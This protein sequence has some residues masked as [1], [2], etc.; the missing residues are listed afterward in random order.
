MSLYDDFDAIR[1]KSDQ[2]AGWSSG[3]KLLQSQMQLKKANQTQV[4][5]YVVIVIISITKIISF[6]FFYPA[7]TG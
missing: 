3:I 4:I 1:P 7:K 5:E 2:V 6:T